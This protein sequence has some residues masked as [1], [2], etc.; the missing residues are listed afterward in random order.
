MPKDN[1][2]SRGHAV[3]DKFVVSY[4]GNLGIPQGLDTFIDVAELL[5]DRADIIFMMIG[6]G[7]QGEK[8]RRR[9]E[10][11]GLPNFLFLPHQPYSTVPQIYASSDVN[12]VPQTAEAGFDAVPSKVYR[13]MACARP[14]I[15]ITDPSSD[16]GRLVFRSGCGTVVRPGSA[17]ELADSILNAYRKGSDWTELGIAGRKHVLEFYSRPAVTD[18]YDKLVRKLS[19]L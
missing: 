4:A 10:S 9:T 18:R 15:A 2:F 8:L 6:Q 14:V 19:A 5:K 1:A 3:F 17:R 12:L 7:M 16:L 11:L 13:I